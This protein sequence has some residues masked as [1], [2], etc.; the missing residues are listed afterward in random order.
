M[1][2]RKHCQATTAPRR[3]AMTG[4]ILLEDDPILRQELREFLD[5]CGYTTTAA[6][7]L[8]SFEQLFQPQQ[9]K[10]AVFDLGLPDGDGLQLIQR[11][12]Q[13]GHRLGILVFTA[14]G[15][16]AA[17][18]QGLDIGADHY[19]VKG[20][21]LDELAAS[22]ASL[23]RRIA[24]DAEE[25]PWTLQLGPRRLTPPDAPP[26]QLSQQDLRVLQR[27]MAQ[28]GECVSR[29]QI[30]TAL[31]ED[32]LTYDQRRLDTQMRRLRRN[33]E[34]TS[35]LPLPVKTQRNQGYCFYAQA[36]LLD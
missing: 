6:A 12:R 13:S 27:L 21:D 1:R 3:L 26:V 22:L 15:G 5:D 10:L 9:H 19:L 18:I 2:P 31:G 29:Q 32:F 17:R 34:E 25:R 14:R 11:L 20:C 8:E 7:D 28:A 30:I 35:G 23:Q 33:V 36:C 16:S 4:L 24:F